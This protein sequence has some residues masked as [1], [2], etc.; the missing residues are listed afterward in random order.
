MN[1]IIISTITIRASVILHVSVEA[2]SYNVIEA[3]LIMVIAMI[4]P[5]LTAGLITSAIMP[6]ISNSEPEKKGFI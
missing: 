1:P 4:L 3:I 2:V 6:T 5:S